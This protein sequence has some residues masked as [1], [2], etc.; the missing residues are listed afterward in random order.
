MPTESSKRPKRRTPPSTH[1]KVKTS[2][3]VDED[4]GS[5][6][7][8]ELVEVIDVNKI[9]RSRDEFYSKTPEERARDYQQ[10]S[11]P[12]EV[13]GEGSSHR[14]RRTHKSSGVLG[15]ART[16][17]S[18]ARP[19]RKKRSKAPEP[20]AGDYVYKQ[21]TVIPPP[22]ANPLGNHPSRSPTTSRATK[23]GSLQ[24]KLGKVNGM[25]LGPVSRTASRSTH[26]SKVEVE[27]QRH[28]DHEASQGRSSD[29]LASRRTV[30]AAEEAAIEPRR[31]GA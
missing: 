5:S 21:P 19:H 29:R 4:N 27:A 28:L 13:T 15:T 14:K 9:R 20:A 17:A 24:T 10:N 18:S 7:D 3:R 31:Y 11:M 26:G 30:G 12:R 23:A 16:R 6:T 2:P 8:E 22:E 1:K 25:R